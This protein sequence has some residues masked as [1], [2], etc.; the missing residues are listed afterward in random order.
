MLM[1]DT[2]PRELKM[3]GHLSKGLGE[4]TRFETKLDKVNMKLCILNI[5][6]SYWEQF[7]QV[8]LYEI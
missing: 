2:N 4:Q 7:Q 8:M 5:Q 1:A 6:Q 3:S